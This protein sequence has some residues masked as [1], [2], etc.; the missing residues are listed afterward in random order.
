MRKYRVQVEGGGVL[1]M[2]ASKLSVVLREVAR[3]IDLKQI[4]MESN[5]VLA[6]KVVDEGPA[7]KG[8][9]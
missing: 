3:R 7:K 6:L 1:Q 5:G 9:K 2:T 8:T 4:E